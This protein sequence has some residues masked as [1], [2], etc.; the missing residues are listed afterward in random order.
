MNCQDWWWPRAGGRNTWGSEVEGP[1]WW[2]WWCSGCLSRSAHRWPGR[3]R[4]AGS[5][6]L[7]VLR[8]L[9]EQTQWL[10]YVRVWKVIWE[11]KGKWLV[12]KIKLQLKNCIF[13]YCSYMARVIPGVRFPKI[14][15]WKYICSL[16]KVKVTQWCPTVCDPM[17][18]TVHVILQVRILEWVAIPFS[19]GSSQPRDQTQVSCVA[20]RFFTIWA[21]RE[22]H[23]FP[24]FCWNR[25]CWW[26]ITSQGVQ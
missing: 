13:Y 4:R 5:G 17:D 12:F 26:L 19:R 16:E 10:G 3:P 25:V 24:Y 1:H 22:T 14:I 21:T 11:R 2:G 15:L 8:L 6:G 9:W 7:D 20:D 18:F 23:Q